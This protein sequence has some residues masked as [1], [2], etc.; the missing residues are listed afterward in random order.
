[1]QLDIVDVTLNPYQIEWPTTADV[2]R[3]IHVAALGI[4]GFRWGHVTIL[5]VGG[6][7]L[8]RA[9]HLRPL[10]CGAVGIRFGAKPEAADFN[11]GFRSAPR[12]DIN[13]GV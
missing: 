7:K 13:Q 2:I 5:S 8:N 1:M 11:M 12:A 6:S 3:D 10:I 9:D 4:A